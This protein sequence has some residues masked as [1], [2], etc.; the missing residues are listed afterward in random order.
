MNENFFLLTGF[1]LIVRFHKC[2]ELFVLFVLLLCETHKQ[3]NINT[4]WR[5]LVTGEGKSCGV[6]LLGLLQKS[7]HFNYRAQYKCVSI[8]FWILLLLNKL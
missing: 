1:V 5:Y 6:Y 8:V 3:Q 4:A 7:H 2:F